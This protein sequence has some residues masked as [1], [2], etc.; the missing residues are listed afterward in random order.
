MRDAVA[1]VAWRSSAE[2]LLSDDERDREHEL[3]AADAAFGDRAA[4]EHG[5]ELPPDRPTPFYIRYPRGAL[6]RLVGS[7]A[8]PFARKVVRRLERERW[9]VGHRLEQ[10]FHGRPESPRL[11]VVEVPEDA[12]AGNALLRSTRASHM[13]F[14]RPGGEVTTE[15]L[16]AIAESLDTEPELELLYGDSRRANGVRFRAPAFSPIRLRE[17]DCLGPV[18]VAAVEPL[19]ARGGFRAGADAAHVLDIALRTPPSGVRRMREVL[20]VG[21][22]IDRP[23]GMGAQAAARVVREHLEAAGISASVTT[24]DAG[25]RVVDYPVVGDPLVSI[26]IPTRGTSGEV[27]GSSRT[28]VIEAVRGICDR[29]TWRN[30]EIVV[31]ADDATP[32]HVIDELVEVA[33]DRLVL[34]RWTESFNFS[35]KMNRGVAVARGDY[36][37]MLNDDVDVVTPDWIE[38][39]LGLAQ[40]DGIGMVGAMLY[41]EDGAVQHLGHIHQGGGA[42]HVGFGIIPGALAPLAALSITR[43]VSGVTAACALLRADVVRDVGGFSPVFPGNYNDVDLSLK[44][45]STGRSIVVT[46]AARLY[47]F[48]S[49]TR[50]AAVLPSEFDA[51]ARRWM[52]LIQ[53]DEYSR[54]LEH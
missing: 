10:S 27:A 7:P 37:L 50:E 28:F 6:R 47:H 5:G 51:L 15:G 2:H 42:G 39:M 40:Q 9:R 21:E 48:E 1:A 16:H 45:R 36:H 29:T 14:V 24:D 23:V 25:H 46:G 44:V 17:E 4:R 3:H 35:A 11:Q 33:G 13:V 19:L 30:V 53:R 32:Q 38:R 43:E 18:V 52:S 12:S 41:F 22:P 49:R 34:V 26:I 54:E 20:G 31:V 8:G